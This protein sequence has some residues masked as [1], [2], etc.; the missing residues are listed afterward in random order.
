M[1]ND[2]QRAQPL[3]MGGD[4]ILLVDNQQVKKQLRT[5]LDDSG[6]YTLTTGEVDK[7]IKSMEP[8]FDSKKQNVSQLDR[9]VALVRLYER[10]ISVVDVTVKVLLEVSTNVVPDDLITATERNISDYLGTW[11]TT[12]SLTYATWKH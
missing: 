1:E 3:V 5:G 8:L 11:V 7:K 4:E 10:L 2:G 6:W 9:K 12:D